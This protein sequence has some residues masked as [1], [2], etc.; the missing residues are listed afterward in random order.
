MKLIPDVEQGPTNKPEV[1]AVDTNDQ[2]HS[3]AK[4]MLLPSGCK[5][6]IRQTLQS[7][8]DRSLKE[9]HPYKKPPNAANMPI[10]SSI[11][12]QKG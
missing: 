4:S 9:T 2:R 6:F 3:T 12:R 1:I 10:L 5:T 7:V 11:L 8:G